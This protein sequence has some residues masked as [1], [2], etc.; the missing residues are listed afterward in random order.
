MAVIPKNLYPGQ[1]IGSD[2]AYPQGKAQN[3]TVPGDATGTPL[4]KEWVNDLWGFLQTILTR[5]NI[6][7]SGTPDQVGASQYQD[8]LNLRLGTMSKLRSVGMVAADFLRDDGQDVDLSGAPLGSLTLPR[9]LAWAADG[10]SLIVTDTTAAAFFEYDCAIPFDL[11]TISYSAVTVSHAAEGTLGGLA[12]SADGLK[13]FGVEITD[14]FVSEW[15]LV[16]PF[17]L[18]GATFSSQFNSSPQD[19]QMTGLDFNAAGSKMYLTS[20]VGERTYQYSVAPAFD[21]TGV[22]YDSVSLDLSAEIQIPRFGFWSADGWR[23]LAIG[24]DPGNSEIQIAQYDAVTKYSLTGIVYLAGSLRTYPVSSVAN[25]CGTDPE[26]TR[27]A[28]QLAS[29]ARTEGF[30]VNHAIVGI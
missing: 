24:G 16:T 1:T 21:M 19:S 22:T 14:G 3:V 9:G 8:A 23:W 6:T 2:P 15:D 20:A 25:G 29:P 11:S 30:T 27:L 18:S 5:A 4:E 26:R 7:P 17:R 13:L 10:Y 28:V 12:F